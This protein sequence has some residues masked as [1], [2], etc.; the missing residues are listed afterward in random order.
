M[1]LL[2]WMLVIEGPPYYS[3]PID[4]ITDLALLKAQ[5]ENLSEPMW[6]E[7]VS[8]Y[9]S[10]GELLH[11]G[12]LLELLCKSFPRQPVFAE[13]LM[14]LRSL[15]G[16]PEAAILLGEQILR[17]HP[18]YFTIWPNLARVYFKAGQPAKGLNM[19]FSALERGPVQVN[20]WKLLLR[21]L[22]LS[23]PDPEDMLLQLAQKI[24]ENP[25]LLSLKYV[26]MVVCVR[27]GNY[28]RAHQL[29][30]DNPELAAHDDIRAF[31]AATPKA[32]L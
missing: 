24:A 14:I 5:M 13:A 22:A 18:N 29:L 32:S 2:L 12:E 30:N 16:Q 8:M 4:P 9:T 1:I 31:L 7:K 17:E 27:F 15:E 3:K 10:L 23:A 20:D 6:L 26:L 11:A 25:Q 21:N 19:M 28:E